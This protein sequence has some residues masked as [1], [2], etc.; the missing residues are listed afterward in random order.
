MID[1]TL[2]STCSVCAASIVR[3]ISVYAVTINNQ[4]NPSIAL[5]STIEVNIGIICACLPSLRHPITQAWPRILAIRRRRNTISLSQSLTSIHVELKQPE[6][7]L[8]D[9]E[10]RRDSLNSETSSS[11]AC[12]VVGFSTSHTGSLTKN[13]ITTSG[14]PYPYNPDL[15]ATALPRAQIRTVKETEENLDPR[16]RKRL[17]A[18][19]FPTIPAP[20]ARPYGPRPRPPPPLQVKPHVLTSRTHK[21]RYG[22]RMSQPLACIPEAPSLPDDGDSDGISSLL[23]QSP[24]GFPPTS[25][26]STYTSTFSISTV[27]SSTY[28]NIAP[29]DAGPWTG[30]KTYSYEILGGP[31]ALGQHEKDPRLPPKSTSRS[32]LSWSSASHSSMSSA[33]SSRRERAR[34]EKERARRKERDMAREV[35]RVWQRRQGPRPLGPREMTTASAAPTRRGG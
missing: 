21:L 14:S 27:D 2:T 28:G 33:S 8:R 25:P 26:S 6:P 24:T 20:T 9:S 7:S 18:P 19:P 35:D 17:P 11:K 34:R 30:G 32:R 4:N 23:H 5:W 15:G 3:L 1:Q 13:Q 16:T 22:R 29:W 10:L 31:G 12:N